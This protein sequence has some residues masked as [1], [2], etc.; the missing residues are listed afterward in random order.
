VKTRTRLLLVVVTIFVLSLTAVA[1]F[2]AVQITRTVRIINSSGRSSEGDLHKIRANML[3]L[4]HTI[5]VDMNALNISLVG[6]IDK[7]DPAQRVEFEDRAKRFDLWLKDQKKEAP[8]A[9]VIILRPFPFVAETAPFLTKLDDLFQT[10]QFDA[11]KLFTPGR[12]DE[13]EIARDFDRVQ[14]DG[15]RLIEQAGE[16][17]AQVERIDVFL[18]AA[19]N[20]LPAFERLLTLTVLVLIGLCGWL[21]TLMFR[22]FIVP[23]RRK[24]IESSEIIEKQV[25][26]AHFGELAAGLAHEIRNPLTAINARLFTLQKTVRENTPESEDAQVI[27]NE[28]NR[29]DRTLKDFLRLARPPEPQMVPMTA[30]S[31]L[32]EV[33]LLLKRD[34]EG[35]AVE[36]K[37]GEITPAKFRADPQQLKQVL[38]NLVQNAAESIGQ[39]PGIIT[40][41]ARTD[42][43]RLK[44]NET[45]VVVIEVIDT[46]PGIAP[47]VQDRLFD[48]F[49]ST[50]QDGTGLGLPI[51]HR[52]VDK[53]GGAIEFRSAPGHT[54]FGIVLP[55]YTEADE[56]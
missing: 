26:L 6:F 31:A 25:K 44:G 51:S 52:I 1:I 48:P 50:K 15:L 7:R 42:T 8:Q 13:P 29:L 16:A 41:N 33:Q 22:G 21:I 30:A 17:R 2:R 38:I 20:V 39:G 47:Q 56:T 36:V 49:F 53:H 10:Y 35:R 12:T 5:P 40:L 45:N 4:A 27:R 9:K 43:K 23:L 54:T 11:Q 34:F 3:Q 14:V 37:L 32:E 28:I 18:E 46:G 55:V 19:L 24:L